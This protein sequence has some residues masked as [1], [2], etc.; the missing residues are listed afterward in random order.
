MDPGH[1][2][3]LIISSTSQ[4]KIV[5]LEIACRFVEA[6]LI[7]IIVVNVYKIKQVGD[8]SVGKITRVLIGQ[9]IAPREIEILVWS[10]IGTGCA[11][12]CC[13]M[14]GITLFPSV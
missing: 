4:T 6:E 10:S 5:H 12:A 8:R 14:V 1:W 2:H 13:G 11:I 7:S 3:D 9:A